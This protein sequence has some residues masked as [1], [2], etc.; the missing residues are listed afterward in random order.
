MKY[1][2]HVFEPDTGRHFHYTNL[3]AAALHFENNLDIG[4][5]QLHRLKKAELQKQLAALHPDDPTE[6]D[7]YPFW[8]S[9]CRV[10][11]VPIMG[12][13]DVE[14]DNGPVGGGRF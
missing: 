3:R 8:A 5:R 1:A 11:R 14:N 9:A 12:I 13:K 7:G 6:P 2:I 4:E 10:D